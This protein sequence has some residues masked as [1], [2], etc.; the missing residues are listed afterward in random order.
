[1]ERSI[2][3]LNARAV[4]RVPGEDGSRG[5]S[6]VA[7]VVVSGF[8]LIEGPRYRKNPGSAQMKFNQT[9]TNHINAPQL[10]LLRRL[11]EVLLPCFTPGHV[12]TQHTKN[13]SNKQH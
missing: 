3:V 4:P 6:E 13:K 9:E 11:S 10:Y 12:I 8:P 7:P 1:M 2:S 5:K